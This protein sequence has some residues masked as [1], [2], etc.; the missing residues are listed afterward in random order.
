MEKPIKL[1]TVIA[2][3]ELTLGGNKAVVVRIGKPQRPRG[4]EFYACPYHISSL[5]LDWLSYGTGVDFVHA[6]QMALEKIGIELRVLSDAHGGKLHWE[7]GAEG[8]VGFPLREEIEREL[9]R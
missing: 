4:D 7:G 1:G 8:D 2:T 6:L 5:G 3:R 9:K